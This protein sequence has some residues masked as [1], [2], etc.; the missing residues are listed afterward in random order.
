MFKH[1]RLLTVSIVM[2]TC[3]GWAIANAAW[4]ELIGADTRDYLDNLEQVRSNEAEMALREAEGELVRQRLQ[5]KMLI[6]EQLSRGAITLEEAT[7]QFED[8]NRADPTILAVTRKI[9][10]AETERLAHAMQAMQFVESQMSEEAE[11]IREE[12]TADLQ[13]QMC[14]LRHEEL[15]ATP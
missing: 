13:A 3:T 11:S 1:V 2:V 14:G 4:I 7:D 12:R 5:L 8:L 9:Y 6:A 10:P 15:P